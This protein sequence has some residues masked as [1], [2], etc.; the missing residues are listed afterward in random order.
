MPSSTYDPKSNDDMEFA[1]YQVPNKKIINLSKMDSKYSSIQNLKS[2]QDLVKR[3]NHTI[4]K[5]KTPNQM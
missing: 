1:D 2:K 5:P 4:Y 3:K